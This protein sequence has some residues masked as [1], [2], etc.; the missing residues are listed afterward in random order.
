MCQRVYIA[1]SRQLPSVKRTRANPHL[2]VTPLD[3]CS[4]FV[5]RYFRRGFDNFFVA[6]AHLPCGCGFPAISIDAVKQP[7]PVD[8]ADRRTMQALRDY[9]ARNLGRRSTAQMVLFFAGLEERPR[10]ERELPLTALD[11]P[12]FRLRP[13]ELLTLHRGGGSAREE[14]PRLPEK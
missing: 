9:L 6:S 14:R 2:E 3:K 8:Q 5:K 12:E 7:G 13:S 4:A 10:N 11:D 1:A